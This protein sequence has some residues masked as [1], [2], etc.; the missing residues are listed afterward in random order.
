MQ[1]DMESWLKD[2]LHKMLL[3]ASPSG[4]EEQITALF[5]EQLRPFVDEVTTDVNGNCIAH[6]QGTGPKVMIMAHADEI[7]LMI[8]YIDDRGFLYF[9]EIG[10]ID[11]NLLPGQRVNIMGQQG[12]VTGVIGKKPIH[13]QDKSE[14]TKQLE[15]EDLWIDIAAKDK[16]EAQSKVQIGDVATLQGNPVQL[17]DTLLM[18]RSLDDKIGLA[19]L[20]GLAQ[21]L[22][23]LQTD[24]DIYLVASVQEELGA[25]GAKMITEAIRPDIGIAIDVTH[26]TDYPTMSPTKDGDISLGKGAVIPMGPNM[27]KGINQQLISLAK[28][29]GIPYQIEAIARPT[30]TDAREIQVAGTGIRTGLISIPCRYMHTP[31]EVVSLADA[32]SAITLLSAYLHTRE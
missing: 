7:G 30:G 8:S 19:V 11:T 5:A 9:K 18:S 1:I 28:S 4:S 2:I 16:S 22:Q 20:M 29:N 14:N 17:N 26:A 15:P 31:S 3:T 6:K 24:K 21:N 23:S 27:S 13:L 12:L 32:D 25:R 10:G